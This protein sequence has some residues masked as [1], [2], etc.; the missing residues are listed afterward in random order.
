MCKD[1]TDQAARPRRYVF[2]LI[3]GYSMLG[4][5]CALEALTLSNRHSDRQRYYSW[6]LLS[7][8]GKPT[9]AWNGVTVEVDG[10]LTELRR[11]DTLVVCAGVD[12]AA[13]ATRPVLNWLRRETRKGISYGA[14]SS[15][16]YVLALAGLIGDRRVT[17]HWEYTDALAE[18]L[19]A[20]SIQDSIYS[21]DG[22]VFTCAGGASS[23]DLILHLIAEDYGRAVSDWVAEQMVYTA[24]RD[25]S[26][27]Q[28]IALQG[29]VAV[30][31]RKLAQAIDTMRAHIEEPLPL[32][33]LAAAIGVSQRQLERL[34][35]RYLETTPSRYYLA[36]R[37]EKARNLLRQTG[38]G[39]TEVSVQCG[40]AS[41][42]HFSRAYKA[43]YG[44][45]PSRE[46]SGGQ[47]LWN[48][49]TGR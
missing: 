32:S 11:G 3:P 48:P 8:D 19:P 35:A 25:H 14:L 26:Q 37:L 45:A 31:D 43:A 42:S 15:G 39:I 13:G 33:R 29:R 40:F 17:T 38:L 6:L 47:T 34:F 46:G 10:G 21:V 2:L 44:T 12:A 20:A 1:I 24:P 7:A 4:F 36:M 28:R 18:I 5:T 41:P 16:T 49:D 30:R 22:R 27:S 9:P 23:M